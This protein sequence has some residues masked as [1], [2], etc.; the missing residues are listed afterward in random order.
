MEST[1]RSIVEETCLEFGASST[2]R[3]KALRASCV[4]LKSRANMSTLNSRGQMNNRVVLT[5][6]SLAKPLGFLLRNNDS[7]SATLKKFL[8]LK[9]GE[10]AESN[11]SGCDTTFW[12]VKLYSTVI[13]SSSESESSQYSRYRGNP[14]TFLSANPRPN[15]NIGSPCLSLTEEK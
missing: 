1:S 7:I 15:S 14:E 13:E 3:D 2:M 11:K 6:A 4:F 9:E 12:K 10:K 8:V 5:P